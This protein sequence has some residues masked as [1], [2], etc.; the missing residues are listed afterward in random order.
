MLK[1]LLIISLSF[2]SFS[3]FVQEEKP[4]EKQILFPEYN[5]D[6][7]LKSLDIN[8]ASKR[9]SAKTLSRSVQ[10]IMADVFPLLEEEQWDEALLL[11]DQIKGLEKA[12]DTDFAQMWYYYA[13]VHFSQ[14]N[15]RL[16][17]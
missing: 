8:K 4:K 10:R 12:T 5:L 11:L 13:Y 3:V 16:A 7:C 6:D 9:R 15:L 17:K 14:D 2:I 1:F